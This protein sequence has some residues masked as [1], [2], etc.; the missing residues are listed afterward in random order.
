M[1]TRSIASIAL[2][3]IAAVLVS[4]PLSGCASKKDK[5]R[6]AMIDQAETFRSKLQRMPAQIDETTK[7]LI[8]ATAGQNPNRADD[9]RSFVSSLNTL[10]EQARVV[11]SEA[12]AA[13]V[14]AAKYFTAWAKEA[15]KSPS[16]DRPAVRE[17]AALSRAQVNQAQSYLDKA[18]DNFMELIGSYDNVAKRLGSDLSEKSVLAAQTDVQNAISKSLDVRN[19]I[20]RLDDSIDA[21]V[22]AK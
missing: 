18:R 14:D 1:N 6:E 20:D 8:A 10:R 21:A 16:A 15:Q 19:D 7:R 17:A 4:S 12:N 22:A 11:G 3:P 13:E 5:A 2:I 9:Y